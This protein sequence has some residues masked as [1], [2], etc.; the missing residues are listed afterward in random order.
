M[1]TLNFCLH[2]PPKFNFCYKNH[3]QVWGRQTVTVKFTKLWNKSSLPG[4]EPLEAV[5]PEAN[6]STSLSFS[7][8]ISKIEMKRVPASLCCWD[9]RMGQ[10]MCKGFSSVSATG[11]NSGKYY[12][13]LILS[14][15]PGKQETLKNNNN[16]Y[17]R[18]PAKCGFG[19]ACYKM[20]LQN[21]RMRYASKTCIFH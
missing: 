21:W 2:S 17:K 20:K 3:F 4:F 10:Y 13:S 12:L 1:K 16:S 11:W 19:K 6:F 14:T 15:N 8:L 5:W 18:S 7:F 9:T